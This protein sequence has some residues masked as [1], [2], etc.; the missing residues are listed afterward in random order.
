MMQTRASISRELK[1]AGVLLL[2]G[3]PVTIAS[4]IWK[5][6][7]AFLLF[8]GI[9]GLLIVA[10]IVV[11]LFSIVASGE[12]L[13][14]EKTSRR[15]SSVFSAG[16]AAIGTF[17]IGRLLFSV[18][19]GSSPCPILVLPFSRANV[20][21]WRFT[22][23]APMATYR[24]PSNSL[25][26]PSRGSSSDPARRSFGYDSARIAPRDRCPGESGS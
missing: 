1:I 19:S 26:Y 9:G 15:L 22:E 11:Y 7:L 13:D 2:A 17:R 20:L 8:A 18:G 3:L 23:H 6:P 12:A 10:G 14:P 25:R 24:A 21:D 16:I 4:L 5:T